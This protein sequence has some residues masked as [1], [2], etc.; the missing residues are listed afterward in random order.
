MTKAG[1]CFQLL[2]EISPA[3]ANVSVE[4]FTEDVTTVASLTHS[5]L[6]V[7]SDWTMEECYRRA[8]VEEV[9]S[10]SDTSAMKVVQEQTECEVAVR[11]SPDLCSQ[12]VVN[13]PIT[14]LSFDISDQD[15]SQTSRGHAVTKRC[16]LAKDTNG[17]GPVSDNL[18]AKIEEQYT[19][20]L[21][22]LEK[23]TVETDYTESTT[24]AENLIPTQLASN[25]T[26]T[27][28]HVPSSSEPHYIIDCF[29]PTTSNNQKYLSNVSCNT[30]TANPTYKV[31]PSYS[32]ATS[33]TYQQAS[34]QQPFLANEE[35]RCH[36]A[37]LTSFNT[38]FNSVFFRPTDNSCMGFTTLV[39]VGMDTGCMNAENNFNPNAFTSVHSDYFA[40]ANFHLNT[41]RQSNL[42]KPLNSR[43][44]SVFF[45]PPNFHPP[46]PSSVS[47]HLTLTNPIGVPN[48]LAFHSNYHMIPNITPSLSSK[49]A[50]LGTSGSTDNDDNDGSMLCSS[51][52]SSIPEVRQCTTIRY[53]RSVNSNLEQR[54]THY[55]SYPG[56]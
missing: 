17:A 3:H 50:P 52:E 56:Q 35:Q 42:S 40:P 32:V 18:Y 30:W 22:A 26:F 21:P 24:S 31:P 6:L 16:I 2:S 10:V 43:V 4:Q 8:H 51:A 25:L 48:S 15:L 11:V 45:T 53:R 7:T 37:L 13:I 34:L 39:S 23:T 29:Q 36:N 28:L 49:A 1:S 38:S 20:A 47:T 14:V 46:T 55:C 41:S 12:S 5:D 33:T 27:N 54:R 19:N 9:L 44:S